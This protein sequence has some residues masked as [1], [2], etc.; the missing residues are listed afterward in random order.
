MSTPAT[1]WRRP[2]MSC[3]R[4]P[5]ADGQP[6]PVPPSGT[7]AETADGTNLYVGDTWPID[8]LDVDALAQQLRNTRR[9]YVVGDMWQAAR[10]AKHA[11]NAAWNRANQL[12]RD[13]EKAARPP[14]PPKVVRPR[15]GQPRDDGLPCRAI[16]GAGADTL[17]EGPCA[18]HG[19]STAIRDQAAQ[20]LLRQAGRISALHRKARTRPL[21]VA[22]ELQ[23]VLAWRAIA[24]APEELRRRASRPRPETPP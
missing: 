9:I 16:A 19:G 15:C 21:T 10:P 3:R 13:A 23:L 24:A 1:P 5:E 2:F 20:E 4:P 7:I 12:R 8:G 22:E 18:A 11:I 6:L 17:G 14:A